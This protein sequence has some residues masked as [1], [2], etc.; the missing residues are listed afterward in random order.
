MADKKIK[1]LVDLYQWIR[2]NNNH[3]PDDVIDYMWIAVREKLSRESEEIDFHPPPKS[4]EDKEFQEAVKNIDKTI[5]KNYSFNKVCSNDT[6][7]LGGYQCN[8]C[9]SVWNE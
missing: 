1:E 5:K 3:T 4:Q 2:K 8:N 6:L 7:C 9:N